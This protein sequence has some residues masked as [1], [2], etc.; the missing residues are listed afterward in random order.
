MTVHKVTL[1]G[2]C[3][4]MFCYQHGCV[5]EKATALGQMRVYDVMFCLQVLADQP[6][7]GE[8]DHPRVTSE[9]PIEALKQQAH[10]L[11]RIDKAIKTARRILKREV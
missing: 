10:E 7:S 3:A 5:K 8:D 2:P 11:G 6:H 1:C 9:D 4:N